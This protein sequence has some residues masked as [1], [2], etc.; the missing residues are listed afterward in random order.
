MSER[1]RVGDEA[2]RE[3]ADIQSPSETD[4]QTVPGEGRQVDKHTLNGKEKG[5]NRKR[6]GEYTPTGR[7]PERARAAWSSFL[8]WKVSSPRGPPSLTSFRL[9]SDVSLTQRR[10]HRTALSREHLAAVWGKM[11]RSPA[12][13]PGAQE[14]GLDCGQSREKCRGFGSS[15]RHSPPHS[16]LMFAPRRSRRI[17]KKLNWRASP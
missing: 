15:A 7:E 17:G 5:E 11:P 8:P 2:V 12:F 16:P 14:R 10:H 6:Q 4:R 13:L 3:P 1:E 9:R